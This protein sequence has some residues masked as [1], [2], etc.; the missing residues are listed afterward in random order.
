MFYLFFCALS[1]MITKFSLHTWC[2]FVCACVRIAADAFE[3]VNNRHRCGKSGQIERHAL[4]RQQPLK[5][6]ANVRIKQWH[7]T[8]EPVF[9]NGI[10]C[11]RMW[12]SICVQYEF[13]TLVLDVR[14]R[15]DI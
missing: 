14:S 7:S 9:L 15:S 6:I 8:L 3:H 12:V 2:T 4:S 11:V 10:M 5:S 1:Q 13:E